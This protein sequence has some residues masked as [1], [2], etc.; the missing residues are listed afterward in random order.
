[1]DIEYGCCTQLYSTRIWTDNMPPNIQ[2]LAI[3]KTPVHLGGIKKW[4][5]FLLEQCSV[6]VLFTTNVW[7]LLTHW[8]VQIQLSPIPIN[9]YF[10]IINSVYFCLT[11]CQDQQHIS[12]FRI[13]HCRKCAVYNS[14]MH[15]PEFMLNFVGEKTQY[16]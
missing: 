16:Y 11:S 2:Q 3:F 6:N 4:K 14:A 8:Y 7:Q 1:M 13:K 12:A 10:C 5:C 9:W 15:F